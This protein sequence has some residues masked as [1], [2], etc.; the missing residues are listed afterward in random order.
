MDLEKDAAFYAGFLEFFSHME[1]G[2]L[3]DI[4]CRPLDRCI[5]GRPFRKAA[6]VEV[7]CMDVRQI[8]RRPKRVS[9]YPISRA[10]FFSPSMY[11]LTPV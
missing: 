5:D 11:S 9:T 1:H 2:N 4:R 7:L 3:D 6:A 10:F 8:T